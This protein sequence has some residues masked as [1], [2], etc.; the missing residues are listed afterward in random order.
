[1]T[2]NPDPLPDLQWSS[3]ARTWVSLLLFV[4]LL[5]LVVA[6]TSYTRPSLLQLRLH[7]L[8]E[9]YLRNFHLTALPV[10][11]PYA[12]YH[13]THATPGDV[14]F[15]VEVDVQKADGSTKT[16]T[17]PAGEQPLVRFRRYQALADAAGTL[18]SGESN[19][20]YA[21]L[22]PKT[23]AASVLA[24]EEAGGGVLRI[25]GQGVPELEDVA[26]LEAVLRAARENTSNVYEAQVIV[27]PVG[28]ELLRRSTTLEVAPVEG[29]RTRGGPGA[30]KGVP[31][32]PN[33]RP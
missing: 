27:G 5:A 20:A 31:N 22:L 9:P 25:R 6:V 10:S 12:R 14:D 2:E 21:S 17:I 33:Q 7:E 11:Y 29:S 28:V 32:K 19:D 15:L 3:E 24:H 18:V 23:I 4:H 16:V 13:L 30:G 1:M 26:N 8:F